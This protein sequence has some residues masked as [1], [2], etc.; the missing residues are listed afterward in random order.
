LCVGFGLGLDGV[1]WEVML[2]LMVL[3]TVLD[4]QMD[5][6]L[7]D[8]LMILV[9]LVEWMV[10]LKRLRLL[11]VLLTPMWALEL[12]EW[13]VVSDPPPPLGYCFRQTCLE[14]NG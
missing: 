6:G 10:G 11:M 5:S 3:E 7:L 4:W 13:S 8:L 1:E 2:V 9:H 12:P 14:R